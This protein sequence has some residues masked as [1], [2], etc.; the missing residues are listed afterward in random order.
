MREEGFDPAHITD[1]LVHEHRGDLVRLAQK[2]GELIERAEDVETISITDLDGD[3]MQLDVVYCDQGD[4]TCV[5][6]AVPI[7]FPRHCDDGNC[8]ID[9]I[10][11]L[12]EM[13]DVATAG[14]EMKLP[15]KTVS[16]ELMETIARIRVVMNRDFQ[17]E[18]VGFV[19]AYG[20]KIANKP[21]GSCEMISLTPDGF[22]VQAALLPHDPVSISF[23]KEC[24][25][26]KDFQKQILQISQQ[27][28]MFA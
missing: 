21:L 15:K 18:L 5:A 20:G 13:E 10:H 1:V 16:P 25:S 7:A 23:S 12:E 26:A 19:R 17:D 14:G 8:I 28:M 11:E 9:A 3:H 6:V 2:Y 27:A 4:Q 22:K 24:E